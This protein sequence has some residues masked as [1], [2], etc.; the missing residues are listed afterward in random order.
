[1]SAFKGCPN[2]WTSI[3]VPI[4]ILLRMKEGYE[5]SGNATTATLPTTPSIPDLDWEYEE[6]KLDRRLLDP[7]ARNQSFVTRSTPSGLVA[8]VSKASHDILIYLTERPIWLGKHNSESSTIAM[9][10]EGAL[11]VI[12][13][14]LHMAAWNVYFPTSVECWLWRGPSLGLCIFPGYI[15]LITLANGYHH[16]LPM[17]LWK[18]Q[19]KRRGVFTCF[20]DCAQKAK[21]CCKRHTVKDGTSPLWHQIKLFVGFLIMIYYALVI[22]FITVESYLSLR[23]RPAN[24]FLTPQW[25]N[26]WPHR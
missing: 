10:F 7:E 26:Y 8:M 6:D 19:L 5:L 20:R 4:K 16:D 9:T 24:T 23:D 12:I 2:R 1:M 14:M 15:V 17:V 21:E 11:V 13:G 18:M 3:N 25:T 22:L